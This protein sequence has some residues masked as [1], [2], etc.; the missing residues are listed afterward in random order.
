[1]NEQE[2]KSSIF[3]LLKR[4]APDTEPEKMD[5]NENIKEALDIDSFDFLQFIVGLDEQFGLETPEKDYGK[6]TTLNSLLSYVNSMKK[7]NK[8]SQKI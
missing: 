3:Q 2:I 6:L 7:E 4:I 5:P 8:T 1:M